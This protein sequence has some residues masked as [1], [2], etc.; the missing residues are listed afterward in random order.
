[1]S[2]TGRAG[3]GAV[4]GRVAQPCEVWTVLQCRCER[5][6]STARCRC[7]QTAPVPAPNAHT[8]A[9]TH[10][11]NHKPPT[12]GVAREVKVLQQLDRRLSKQ[13]AAP[14]KPA[15]VRRQRRPAVPER[16]RAAAVAAALAAATLVD[17]E[18]RAAAPELVVWAAKV[19]AAHADERERARAHDAGLAGDVQLAAAELCGREVAAGLA[20]HLVDRLEFGVARRLYK[21]GGLGS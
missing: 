21:R 19:D 9:N 11:Q 14:L 16:A 18:D 8:R 1:M 6:C 13:P 4:G 2:T 3:L 7:Q 17:R 10:T 15:A 12:F 5:L 20:Q